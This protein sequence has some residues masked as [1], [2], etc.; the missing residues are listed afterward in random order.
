MKKILVALAFFSAALLL[1]AANA[2]VNR[3]TW[4]A[5]PDAYF[6]TAEE[7]VAWKKVATD[8]QARE[9][10]G[11][12]LAE[13]GDGFE[14][15]LRERIAVADKYFSAGKSR[16]SETLR[17]KVIILFGPPSRFSSKSGREG[18]GSGNS[19][20]AKTAGGVPDPHSN[21][22]P[23]VRGLAMTAQNPIFTLEYDEP[24]APKAIG[25]SFRVDLK[26]KSDAVQEAAEPKDLEDKFEAVARASRVKSPPAL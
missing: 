15:M 7:R 8:D 26:M 22:G 24:S 18:Q 9:F 5:S 3:K 21:V 4:A 11:K 17:G 14:P 16:G 6:L 2:P 13:R 19:D 12:Y 20:R 23:G 25:K 1:S 10:V